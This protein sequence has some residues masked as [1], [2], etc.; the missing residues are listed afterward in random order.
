M[1][2]SDGVGHLL[3][4]PHNTLS[5]LHEL[6]LSYNN[7]DSKSCQVLA[8]RLSS[9]PHLESLD[10]TSNQIGCEGAQLLSQT[11]C[12]NITLRELDLS[13]NGIQY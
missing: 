5:D 3:S 12:T 2:T 11:P 1:L 9:L 7:R 4:L 10:L 6:N 8:H 13:R